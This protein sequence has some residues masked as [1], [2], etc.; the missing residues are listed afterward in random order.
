MAPAGMLA[1]D[2]ERWVAEEPV[3]AWREPFAWRARRWARRNGT[4]VTAAAAAVLVALV[5]LARRA[6]GASKANLVLTCKNAELIQAIRRESEANVALVAANAK[7]QARFDLE[8][9]AISTLRRGQ[10]RPLAQGEAIRGPEGQ[11]AGRSHEVLRQAWRPPGGGVGLAVTPAL[12]Q[13]HHEVGKLTN[14]IGQTDK[15]LATHRPALDVRRRL[16]GEAGSRRRRPCADVARSL[17]ALGRSSRP[18]VG[19]PGRER[20]SKRPARR[21]SP[22]PVPAQRAVVQGR[23]GVGPVANRLAAQIDRRPGSRML[24]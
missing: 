11:A 1:D 18:P 23:A 13:A 21:W 19:R 12:G 6:V 7:A 8:V 16:A 5:G 22:W 15:A 3:T 4:I 9:E 17:I 20:P 10:R 24:V 14:I 2:V